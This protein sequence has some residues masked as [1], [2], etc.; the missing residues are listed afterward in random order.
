METMNTTL[1]S[2]KSAFT[3]IALTSLIA[4]F[5]V[6]T[7]NAHDAIPGNKDKEIT[8]TPIGIENAEIVFNLKH[9]N[10]GAD[11]LY[12]TLS[13]KEG[14]KLYSQVVNAKNFDRTFKVNAEV[15]TVFLTVTNARTKAQ[16]KFEIS[17]R[18]HVVEDL[19]INTVN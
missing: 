17:P 3:K 1:A 4:I 12:I 14:V 5:S 8:V 16:D 2:V 11:K 15:G 7:V 10:T 18:S 6:I 13:D 9:L 19:T